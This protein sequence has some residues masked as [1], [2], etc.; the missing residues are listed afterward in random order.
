MDFD[1][2]QNVPMSQQIY[3]YDE[4][5]DPAVP[6]DITGKTVFISIKKKND[7]REDD[8]EALITSK[9][10]LHFD[11]A[12][13][14]TLWALTQTQTNIPLG[15]YKGDARIYTSALVFI[16]ST[17]FDVNIIPVVTQRIV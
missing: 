10:T 17:T 14:G 6:Y 2:Q 8:T 15:R 7:F 1:I 9:L 11:P 16:N 12:G 5:V 13:G 4:S 3:L